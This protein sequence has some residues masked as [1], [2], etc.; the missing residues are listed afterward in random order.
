MRE[1]FI[2]VVAG[3]AEAS[4]CPPSVFLWIRGCDKLWQCLRANNTALV[5][6]MCVSL[7][8][9]NRDCFSSSSVVD[10]YW[11]DFFFSKRYACVVILINKLEL[12]NCLNINNFDRSWRAAESLRWPGKT[13]ETISSNT[14][15]GRSRSSF[16]NRKSINLLNG[17]VFIVRSCWWIGRVTASTGVAWGKIQRCLFFFCIIISPEPE[18]DVIDVPSSKRWKCIY[19]RTLAGGRSEPGRVVGSDLTRLRHGTSW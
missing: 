1:V 15:F 2:P 16:W 17:V 3:W 12:F 19:V 11:F 14:T 8:M 10:A 9:K 7:E 5:S 4:V 18:E 6:Y 13:P